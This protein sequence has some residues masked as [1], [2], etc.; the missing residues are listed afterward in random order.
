[1]IKNYHSLLKDAGNSL[2]NDHET[3]IDTFAPSRDDASDVF[4]LLL[5]LIPVPFNTAAARF[6]AGCKWS[7]CE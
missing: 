5:T 6:F 7:F 1:M 4:G 3:F 2:Q